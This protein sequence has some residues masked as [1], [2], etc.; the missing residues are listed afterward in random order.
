[1]TGIEK[2]FEVAG[3]ID[4]RVDKAN[5]L[6]NCYIITFIERLTG[7]RCE[8]V[9]DPTF[10]KERYRGVDDYFA[11]ILSEAIEQFEEE[12]LL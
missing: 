2:L 5:F 8:Q 9:L 7:K 3:K 6:D 1:M 11:M 4:I 12:D 10:L